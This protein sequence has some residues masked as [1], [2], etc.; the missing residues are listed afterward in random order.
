MPEDTTLNVTVDEIDI[1]FWIGLWKHRASNGWGHEDW[2]F[3]KDLGADQT[4]QLSSLKDIILAHA[5][6]AENRQMFAKSSRAN[7]IQSQSAVP[8]F[9]GRARPVRSPKISKS[10]IRGAQIAQLDLGR[11]ICSHLSACLKLGAIHYL[12]FWPLPSLSLHIF[13]PLSFASTCYQ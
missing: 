1:A 2:G 7:I 3:E 13:L 12:Q 8:C 5:T 4:S 10:T 11:K 6:S 9:F